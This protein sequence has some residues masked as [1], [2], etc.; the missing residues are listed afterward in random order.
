MN[1]EIIAHRGYSAI[2]PENTLSAFSEAMKNGAHSVEFDVQLSADGVPVVI[3]D[4]T[5][6]RIASR[7]DKITDLTVKELKSID[8][9]SW[10]GE[11][12]NRE[13][14]LTLEETLTVL[15]ALERNVYLDIKIYDTWTEEELDRFAKQVC[16]IV[17]EEGW[18]DRCFVT[19]F[20]SEFVTCFRRHCRDIGVGYIVGNAESFQTQLQNAI[21]DGNA[22][23]SSEYRVLLD[24][25]QLLRSSRENNIDVVAWTIDDRT[26]WQKLVDLGIDRLVT[27]SLL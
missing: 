24:N 1:V 25:P 4:R 18:D 14:I 6:D 8:I 11:E 21:A 16:K 27:N 20:I 3:H 22:V 12:F 23:I 17:V 19:S 15:K 9:G 5:L 26:H 2:A 13:R 10:F 7:P